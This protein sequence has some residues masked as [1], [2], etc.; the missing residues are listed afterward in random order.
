MKK[1]AFGIVVA[2]AVGLMAEDVAQERFGTLRCSF[3][4]G[5]TVSGLINYDNWNNSAQPTFSV[6]NMTGY[7]LSTCG[8]MFAKGR[9]TLGSD[10]AG[11]VTA[12]NAFTMTKDVK[13]QAAG[14]RVYLPFAAFK[15][16][17]WRTDTGKSGVFPT[18]D[19]RK[20]LFTGK[21]VKRVTFATTGGEEIAFCVS[22]RRAS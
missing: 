19:L 6:S 11:G 10:G 2:L 17:A 14:T 9:W 1:Q 20:G 16:A 18:N 13:S 15:G 21:D 7:V 5:I 8:N 3:G 22:S 4:G 12:T